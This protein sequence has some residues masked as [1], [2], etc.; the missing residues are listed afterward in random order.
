MEVK[1]KKLVKSQLE[2]TF[3]LTAEEFVHHFEHALEHMKSHVKVEGFRPGKAPAKMVEE[4]LKPES[5]LME[6]GEHAVN[7]VYSDYVKENN[8]EPIG[9]PE[10]KIIKIAKGSEFIFSTTVAVM[11]DVDLPDYKEIAKTVKGNDFTVTEEEVQD[12]LNYLQKTRAKFTA[13]NDPAE[14]G[15]FVEIEYSSPEIDKA[16]P[17]SGASLASPRRDAFVLGEA[18]MVK[19]F[20]ENLQ[21]MKTGQ[22]KDFSVVFPN[23]YHNKNFAGKPIDFHVKMA[24]VQKMELPEIN[25]EFAKQLGS[26][27][28]L[29]TLKGSVKQGIEMEKRESE[30]Q[31]KRGEI[32][33]KIAE[34][35]KIELP[36]VMVEYEKNHLLDDLKQKI[37]QNMKISF[38]QYLATVK[39]TEDQLKETFQKEAE[40]RL[41]GFLVLREIGKA[42]NVEVLEQEIEEEVK[43]M[44]VDNEQIREYAKGA[45][46]NEKIFNKLEC[47]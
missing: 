31:R 38:E 35:T 5:L 4:R 2:L 23:D 19:G 39:Q 17:Q 22:E 28:T 6:A 13:K 40:K 15:D 46:M 26:F 47:Q 27:D 32:L 42:E 1:Q 33:E 21:G 14:K 12:S 3:E 41:K 11:P 16:A 45:I 10:V 37:T 24:S 18:K 9:H 7:H 34:K 8:L 30:K 44:K 25:D 43:K 36:D 20:E 29:V